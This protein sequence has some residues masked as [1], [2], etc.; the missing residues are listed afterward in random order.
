MITSTIN[1]SKQELKEIKRRV[2]IS[3]IPKK[4]LLLQ[5]GECS[6]GFYL[7]LTGLARTYIIIDSKQH[8]IDLIG[9]GGFIGYLDDIA[10]G[11]TSTHHIETLEKSLLIF[12]SF[13]DLEWFEKNVQ[14][15]KKM[16][17]II[18]SQNL[19]F[20]IQRYTI[21]L[22]PDPLKRL[23]E[24]IDRIPDIEQR[25]PQKMIAT[26]LNITPGYYSLLKSK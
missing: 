7:I 16:V 21:I 13:E 15:G 8:T 26:Y 6:A 2:V 25:I 3:R 9:G 18:Y 11:T 12:L 17:R 1:V 20:A 23:E 24:L 5:P 10:D 19:A 14:E 22:N 4:T